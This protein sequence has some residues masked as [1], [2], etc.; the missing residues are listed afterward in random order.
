MVSVLVCLTIALV[1]GM[2]SASEPEW[3]AN[4]AIHHIVFDSA[5][6]DG[7]VGLWVWNES[8]FVGGDQGP[9]SWSPRW[10]WHPFEKQPALGTL[11]ADLLWPADLTA[12][13]VIAGTK[14]DTSEQGYWV[15]NPYRFSICGEGPASWSPTWLWVLQGTSARLWE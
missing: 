5:G 11:S 15:W 1:P 8:A 7:Q 12:V 10:E 2:A 9:W 3:P 6:P 13:Q 14:A 4:P